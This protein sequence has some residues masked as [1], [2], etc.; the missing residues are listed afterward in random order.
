MF[1]EEKN[2]MVMN[3][4]MSTVYQDWA[5]LGRF[6]NVNK[7]SKVINGISKVI[8]M[9]LEGLWLFGVNGCFHLQHRLKENGPLPTGEG[10]GQNGTASVYSEFS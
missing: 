1:A 6:K 10:G 5:A 9:S 7:F 8:W 2:L 4:W 3:E